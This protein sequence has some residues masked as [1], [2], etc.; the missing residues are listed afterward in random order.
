MIANIPFRLNATFQ[1]FESNIIL[2]LVKI[3]QELDCVL[4][5]KYTLKSLNLILTLKQDIKRMSLLQSYHVLESVA[6]SIF[7]KHR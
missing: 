1:D 6:K 5:F 4:K 3:K 7:E 2:Y